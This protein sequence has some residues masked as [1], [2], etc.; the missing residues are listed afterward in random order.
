MSP[1]WKSVI[2][3]EF[4][5]DPATGDSGGVDTAGSY[6]KLRPNRFQEMKNWF[7]DG[8]SIRKRGGFVPI[9]SAAIA[10][11]PSILAVFQA[12]FSD[13]TKKLLVH[14]S[15]GFIYGLDGDVFTKMAT[16][17]GA[18]GSDPACFCQ[19]RDNYFLT[20]GADPPQAGCIDEATP[21]AVLRT[22][23]G[24]ETF[25]DCTDETA[26]TDPST[27]VDLGG[28]DT[29]ESGG[30]VYICFSRPISAVKFWI[31]PDNRNQN[32]STVSVWQWNGSWAQVEG[33]TDGTDSGGATLAQTGS[34]SWT[35]APADS[36]QQTINGITGHWYR[37]TVSVVLSTEVYVER[38]RVTAPLQRLQN[39]WDGE[40]R[41]IHGCYFVRGG[42]YRDALAEVSDGI[43]ISGLN[44]GGMSP[45][46]GDCLYVG[47]YGAVRGFRFSFVTSPEPEVNDDASVLSCSYWSRSGTW[48]AL[49]VVDGTTSG[50]ACFAQDGDV[51]FLWPENAE[52]RILA[53]GDVPLYWFKFEVSAQ[54]SSGVTISEIR[55]VPHLDQ[56]GI[57]GVCTVFKHRLFL[58]RKN[59]FQN[60][61]FF[62]AARNPEV[63]SG[64]D[65]GYIEVGPGQPVLWLMSF[66]NELAVGL[67]DGGGVYVL[68]GY[69]PATFGLLR[70]SSAR[71]IGPKT[72]VVVDL[73]DRGG[74]EFGFFLARDGFYRLEGTSCTKISDALD[75]Y[76]DRTS[77][78]HLDFENAHRSCACVVRSRGWYVCAVP[79]RTKDSPQ[80]S[81]NYWFV[82]DYI[83][84]SWFVFDIS[85]ASVACV[86]GD[87][88]SERLVFGGQGDGMLYEYSDAFANDNGAAIDAVF[89]HH[90]DFNTPYLVKNVR[91]LDFRTSVHGD[92]AGSLEVS[93]CRDGE[94]DFRA[95][96]PVS[97]EGSNVDFQTVSRSVDIQQVAGIRL[98]VRHLSSGCQPRI[99][100][101]RWLFEAIREW[102]DR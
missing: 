4:G 40:Y 87:D 84:G 30:A 26:D 21:L 88:G 86:L 45:S 59:D 5:R 61:L 19:Y 72:A 70:V 65:A 7:W 55:A 96:E 89:V 101:W 94:A 64:D 38:L 28:L 16:F 93:W 74:G 46:A 47:Y 85:S 42:S 43:S 50:G 60:G 6:V 10:G 99:Y 18:A 82:L 76:F 97:L 75:G 62:S 29:W 102:H 48:S 2:R 9:N 68:Q 77:D 36:C 56:E 71:C 78:L 53:G 23:D 15:D 39:L 54:L 44:I 3:E 8:S 37:I 27:Y 81:P 66:Y 79:L 41:C 13:G 12:S 69:D 83:R 57:Y 11:Q 32:V 92:G 58:G 1:D 100:G 91:Q 17:S 35:F 98:M 22:D 49:A 24:G 63:L 95:L 67:A 31:D 73:R 33:I 90:E 34:I 14:A 51:T 20:N 52:K 80:E 25:I